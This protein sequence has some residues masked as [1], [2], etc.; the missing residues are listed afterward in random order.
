M[1]VS[2]AIARIHEEIQTNQNNYVMS[3][4]NFLINYLE[5]DPAAA[6]KI[7]AEGKTI[8]QS[9]GA[10]RKE[11]GKNKVNGVGVLSDAEGFEIVLKYY[12]ID[13]VTEEDNYSQVPQ[14]DSFDAKLDDFL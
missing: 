8:T 11:A 1:S 12:G 4:G 14:E 2:K 3:V 6:D 9:I 5:I 10:M 13:P 7:L